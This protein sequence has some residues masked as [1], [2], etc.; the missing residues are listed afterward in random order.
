MK[1][2]GPEHLFC[3][4]ATSYKHSLQLTAGLSPWQKGGEGSIAENRTAVLCLVN[5]FPVPG[6]TLH[7]SGGLAHRDGTS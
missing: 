1:K 5:L 3:R 7:G 2:M 6:L 4:K